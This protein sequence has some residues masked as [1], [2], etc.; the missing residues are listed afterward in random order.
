MFAFSGV[1]IAFEFEFMQVLSFALLLILLGLK[2]AFLF[3]LSAFQ[4][5]ITD[6]KRPVIS[7]GEGSTEG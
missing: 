3:L 5:K 6:E 2:I 4:K 1:L 7:F